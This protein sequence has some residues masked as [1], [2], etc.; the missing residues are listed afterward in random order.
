[1]RACDEIHHIHLRKLNPHHPLAPYASEQ[2]YFSTPDAEA[3]HPLSPE[4]ERLF[5]AR[6]LRATKEEIVYATRRT[7][8]ARVYVYLIRSLLDTADVY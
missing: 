2:Q 1:V 7:M 4:C 5:C 3:T 8:C 6:R